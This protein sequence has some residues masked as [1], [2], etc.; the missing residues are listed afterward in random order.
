MVTVLA[1]GQ[2]P[3]SHDGHGDGVPGHV[4]V[5]GGGCQRGCSVCDDVMLVPVLGLVL[6]VGVVAIQFRHCWDW[7]PDLLPALLLW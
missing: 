7:G 3:G 1:C 4:R 5:R 6:P 2:W